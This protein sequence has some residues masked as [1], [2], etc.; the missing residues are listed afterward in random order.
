MREHFVAFMEAMFRNCHAEAA[1]T[2]QEGEEWWYLP[3]FGVYHPRKPG[4]SR[5]VFDFSTQ[6]QG[7]SLNSVLLTGPDLMNSRLGPSI[8]FNKEPIAITKNIQ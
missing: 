6:F 8:P 4:Q 7:A 5:V 2:V 3:I 1:P